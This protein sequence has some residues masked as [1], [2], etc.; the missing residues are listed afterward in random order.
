MN[1]L[2]I[3]G[4]IL[5]A[6][7]CGIAVAQ[8]KAADV[9][10]LIQEGT[11]F[12]DRGEYDVA[13]RKYE[14][15]LR[16][17]PANE[18]A[19]Y[20]IALSLQALGKNE[21]CYQRASDG[22]ARRGDPRLRIAWFTAAANCADDLGDSK[23]AIKLYK[24]AAKEFPDDGLLFYNFAVARVQQ[25]RPREAR[26]LVEKAIDRSPDHASSH[27]LLSGLYLDAGLRVPS[28][29]ARLR[30]LGAEPTSPRS[31]EAA[32]SLTSLMRA[33]VAKKSEDEI[34]ITIDP[35]PKRGEGDFAT[36]EIMMALS[37]ALRL[38]GGNEDQSEI[39]SLV[40]TID[41]L[42]ATLVEDQERDRKSFVDRTYVE[43]FAK[44]RA[45]GLLEVYSYRA[46]S[47]LG[48]PECEDWLRAHQDKVEEL[49]AFL[50]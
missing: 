49:R 15:A 14:E 21:E 16:L 18:T 34:S 17:D 27:L 3:G 8:V 10:S 46:L 4:A 29:L 26:E 11:R 35:K 37:S 7:T 32:E 28:I 33:G 38:A 24:Q 42:I 2:R 47:S 25:E 20:E 9:E 40:G 50:G 12:H 41:S 5:L 48:L 1:A 30:F 44:L 6:M 36:S 31:G 19:R 43:F 39:E 45:A 23:A 13:I 22:L